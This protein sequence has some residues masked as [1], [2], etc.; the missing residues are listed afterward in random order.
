MHPRTATCL[1]RGSSKRRSA[2][3]SDSMSCTANHRPVERRPGRQRRSGMRPGRPH[4]A[5]ACVSKGAGSRSRCSCSAAIVRVRPDQG[6]HAVQP[7]GGRCPDG[8]RGSQ[9]WEI[10]KG[11]RTRPHSA[12]RLMQLD[13]VRQEPGCSDSTSKDGPCRRGPSSERSC[14]AHTQHAALYATKCQL[15]K[16]TSLLAFIRHASL[17][18][19]IEFEALASAL[20]AT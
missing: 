3:R 15:P 18:C 5:S 19:A 16:E 11:M 14:S 17:A 4:L 6:D 8:L 2:T 12:L 10:P 20:R 7:P 1:Q 9:R 13:G